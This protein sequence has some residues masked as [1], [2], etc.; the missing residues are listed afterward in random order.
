MID[1]IISPKISARENFSVEFL[2]DK[3]HAVPKKHTPK[4]TASAD[5]DAASTKNIGSIA[6]KKISGLA[7]GKN[8]IDHHTHAVTKINPLKP[9]R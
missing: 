8:F 9:M 3:S 1:K 2:S 5:V 7:S 4:V 6:S